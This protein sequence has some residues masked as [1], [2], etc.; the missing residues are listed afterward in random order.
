MVFGE[1]PLLPMR[2]EQTIAT[3][4][5]G[6]E[7]GIES[8][9]DYHQ[10]LAHA[11]STKRC[12]FLLAVDKRGAL[13]IQDVVH[14]LLEPWGDNTGL[15]GYAALLADGPRTLT[16]LELMARESRVID[17]FDVSELLDQ[18]LAYSRISK[19]WENFLESLE[20]DLLPEVH[21]EWLICL[22][23]EKGMNRETLQFTQRLAQFFRHKANLGW[24]EALMLSWY[25]V[26]DALV[27]YHKILGTRAGG[28]FS[29]VGQLDAT[30]LARAEQTDLKVITKANAATATK[31]KAIF[32]LLDRWR[33][34]GT[35][36][37]KLDDIARNCKAF[38]PALLRVVAKAGDRILEFSDDASSNQTM[39]K[40][41]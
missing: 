29:L 34:D 15:R 26:T 28:L 17:Y 25:P 22:A 11:K 33:V 23:E 30:P 36:A 40:V 27:S 19:L 35:L 37:E 21:Q 4:A 12:G 32:C 10:A 8:F 9:E 7:V 24:A 31:L 41:G 14:N 18:S 5:P 1:D 2:I 20:R 39:Q 13:P 38:D 16:G 3:V 6:L